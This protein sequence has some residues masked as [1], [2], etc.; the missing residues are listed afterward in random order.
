[1]TGEE[2][3]LGAEVNHAISEGDLETLASIFHEFPEMR[4]Y[5]S[6]FGPWLSMAAYHGQPKVMRWL[7]EDG[8]DI[9]RKYSNTGDTALVIAIDNHEMEAI[10]LLLERGAKLDQTRVENDPLIVTVHNNDLEIARKL[11]DYGADPHF[12]YT[13]DNGET[14]SPLSFAE[15]LGFDEMARL[16][17]EH[18]SKSNS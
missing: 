10:D 18:G 16:L 12:T 4:D 14:R 8:A 15:E 13:L 6:F 1:M 9:D 2:R 7:L 11:L 17:R 3:N 5:E